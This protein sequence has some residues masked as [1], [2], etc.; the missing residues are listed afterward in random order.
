MVELP[1]GDK[2]SEDY[3]QPFWYNTSTWQTD[4]QTPHH[5]HSVMWQ[6]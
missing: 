6:N 1:E 2:Q 5:M 3:V 4:G